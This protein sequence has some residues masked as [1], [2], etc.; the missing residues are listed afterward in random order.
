MTINV[1]LAGAGAFGIK[2]LDAMNE[3]DDVRVIGVYVPNGAE[4]GS[5]KY[6]YKLDWLE[7][8]RD[9]ISAELDRHPRLVLLGDFNK[10]GRAHV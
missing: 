5:E 3:I 1:A 4:V 8:L 7:K 9:F 10:I 2:D 6:A